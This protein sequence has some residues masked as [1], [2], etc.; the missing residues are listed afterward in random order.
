M[1][2]SAFKAVFELHTNGMVI[3][4]DHNKIE[5]A[6]AAF[7]QLLP[8]TRDYIVDQSPKLLYEIL[9]SVSNC[10]ARRSMVA[11]HQVYNINLQKLRE[12]VCY[13]PSLDQ[14]TDHNKAN[15]RILTC[16]EQVLDSDGALKVLHFQDSTLQSDIENMKSESLATAAHELRTPMTSIVGFSEL[17]LSRDFDIDIRQELLN[18]ILQQ[19]NIT[20]EILNQLFDLARIELQL[21]EDFNFLEQSLWPIVENAVSNL[22]VSNDPRS[23][24]V[25]SPKQPFLVRV[26]A[27]KIRQVI[28][29]VL[30]NAYKYSPEGGEISL[31][32]LK[33]LSSEDM[34]Q[35][36]IEIADQGVGMT[37]EQVKQVF[38]RYWRADHPQKIAGIGLGMSLVHEIM[39]LHTGSVEINSKLGEGTTVILWLPLL[40]NVNPALS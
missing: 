39:T 17:L 9:E 23:V 25:T 8:I 35:V 2:S 15:R 31:R 29:N 16:W 20:M 18:I 30:I 11:G 12:H 33:R 37:S 26:D 1:K 13:C 5:L 7:W 34:P 10:P 36:G 22:R 32:L 19:S 4:N 40:S 3:V 6:N 21:A 38:N 28:N 24:T 27:G 14:S